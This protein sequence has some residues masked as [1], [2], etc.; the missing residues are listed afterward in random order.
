MEG[1]AF[2]S[3]A[4]SG[5]AALDDYITVMNELSLTGEEVP[6]SRINENGTLAVGFAEDFA[7]EIAQAADFVVDDDAA[8]AF[9]ALLLYQAEYMLPQAELA[10]T[11]S[12]D[13]D[14]GMASLEFLQEDGV[15]E[16]VANGAV[17][18]GTARLYA[19]GRCGSL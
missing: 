11:A 6:V 16:A 3:H 12:S 4:S 13:M 18:S 14:Y 1:D 9:D 15:A 10:A 5:F 17:A 8:S 7:E 19:V 2:C